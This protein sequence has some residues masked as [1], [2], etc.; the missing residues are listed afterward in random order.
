M[1]GQETGKDHATEPELTKKLAAQHAGAVVR[2][3]YC[4]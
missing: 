4:N 3:E 2:F 1:L